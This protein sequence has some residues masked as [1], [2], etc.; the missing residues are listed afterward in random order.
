[1]KLIQLSL[2][3]LLTILLNL[4]I[5]IVSFILNLL[6]KG[7]ITIEAWNIM[8]LQNFTDSQGFLKV[9]RENQRMELNRKRKEMRNNTKW[10]HNIN[11]KKKQGLK[12]N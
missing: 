9:L 5:L 12:A 11:V 6:R 8:Y 2:M 3:F 10:Q 4:K 7:I 1:M